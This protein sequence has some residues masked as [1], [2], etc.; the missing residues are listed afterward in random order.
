MG[1]VRKGTEIAT[2][3]AN[4]VTIQTYEVGAD[5]LIF[6][7]ANQVQLTVD[8]ETTD[9]IPLIV[10]GRLIAQK[11]GET[12]VTGNTLVL[13]DNVMNYDLVKILQGGTVKYD[14]VDPTKVIGYT[15][16]VVGSTDKGQRF[17]TRVYSAIY[18]AAGTIVG[19]E[20]IT[21]PNCKG[22]P[23]SFSVEDGT[24]R[25]PEYTI[26]S[27]PDNGEAPY[28]ID[29]VTELP[30]VTEPEEDENNG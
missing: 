10:K 29:I 7:T 23:V 28:D 19:Y 21:Y 3:D 24:F 5:E 12:T 14:T 17:I 4:L 26:K 20:R 11:P 9:K 30:T 13:T 6:D 22:E 27:M 2:I 25:A 15:P 18:N 8:T 1:D 16:P